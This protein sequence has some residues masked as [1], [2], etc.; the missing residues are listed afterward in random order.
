MRL[1]CKLLICWLILLN[2]STSSAQEITPAPAFIS[3]S[4]IEYDDQ[5]FIYAAGNIKIII[6]NYQ[7]Q[8]DKLLYDLTKDLL[9]AEGNV[10]L[11]DDQDN[12]VFGETIFLKDRL[13]T[14]IIAD[15][16]LKFHDNSLLVARLS[17]R[18]NQNQAKLYQAS[19]TPCQILCH[20]PP[21]W[22]LSAQETFIDLDSHKMTYKNLF[23][24]LY[25]WP[26]F[27]TPYFS[28]PTPM[29]KAQSGILVPEIKNNRLGVPFYYRAQPN[30]D[31]TLTPRVAK[32]LILYE[33]EARHRLNHGDYVAQGSY[34]RAP[35]FVTT[36]DQ[37]ARNHKDD[38]YY[39]TAKGNFYQNQYKYGFDLNFASDKAY[40][41]NYYE[42]YDAYLS[43]RL[44]LSQVKNYNY[45]SVDGLYFQSLRAKELSARN[46]LILPRLQTKNVF[47]LNEAESADFIVESNSL[48][49]RMPNQLQ[50]L[51][52]AWQLSVAGNYLTYHGHLLNLAI[53]SKSDLYSVSSSLEHHK[54]TNKV[55]TRHIP[56]IQAGWRYPLIRS[57][58]PAASIMVEPITLVTISRK[59]R[60][61]DKK[62][63]LI[64]AAP[65]EPSEDNLFFA[66]RYSGIHCYEF[67]NKVSYGVNTKILIKRN[68][69]SLFLG[70][71]LHKYP[72]QNYYSY[73]NVGKMEVSFS[74]SLV[75]FYKFRKNQ[76]LVTIKDEAGAN[77]SHDRF[78]LTT[79]MIN[80]KNLRRYYAVGN[81]TFAKNCI[82]QA[83]YDWSYQ[84]T[85]QWLV[86][87]KMRFDI[88]S[89]KTKILC[90][91]IKVTYSYDCVKVV[92]KFS[93]DYMSD[94]SR[95]IKK[96]NSN[97]V[98]I[99]LK[100]LNM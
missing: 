6:D 39:I 67:G 76:R 27:Y 22:Q 49:Y 50:L 1:L 47:H 66:D 61:Q 3:A 45:L 58:S 64:D 71:L 60:A 59:M 17:E 95:G 87:Q 37:T 7:V 65:L 16:I 74:E 94:G 44:Y 34:V 54:I 14:G 36:Q 11:K 90:R 89:H 68:Y 75:L 31:F 85:P 70:Q 86:S 100:I 88:S 81:F 18:I 41:K 38:S 32:R 51:R 4:L 84:L 73:D 99:G 77:F 48:S 42:N 21:I 35:Y 92:G 80:L 40:L 46:T 28:H 78:Q 63:Q 62:F 57:L 55:W 24:E 2:V 83:Y 82:S 79:S 33:L 52:T 43:S 25:G 72:A 9:W 20:R 5:N 30:L 10:R 15:F 56:E 29:A 13:K 53:L 97:T 93:N 98:S 69:L 8:A 23:F 12:V 19:F 91:S 96:L 26:I